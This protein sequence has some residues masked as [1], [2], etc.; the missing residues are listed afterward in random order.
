MHYAVCRL[1]MWKH[2]ICILPWPLY[3]QKIKWKN[4]EKEIYV[5]L[6]GTLRDYPWFFLVRKT[7]LYF[8]KPGK[9]HINFWKIKK[10][11]KKKKEKK[12]KEKKKNSLSLSL[13]QKKKKKLPSSNTLTKYINILLEIVRISTQKWSIG[14]QVILLGN[15]Q[16]KVYISFF[17]GDSMSSLVYIIS[18]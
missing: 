14:L 17:G 13:S 18:N 15:F 5:N 2:P 9:I 1:C 11:K 7:H 16:S 3:T 8:Q 10:K 6:N 4:A 12:K